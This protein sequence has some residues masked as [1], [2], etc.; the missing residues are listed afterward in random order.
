MLARDLA[1]PLPILPL[2]APV[3]DAGRLLASEAVGV[4]S[5]TDPAGRIDHPLGGTR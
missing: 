3:A 5:P 4:A 1:R 2:D